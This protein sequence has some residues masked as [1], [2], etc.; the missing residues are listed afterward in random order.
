VKEKNSFMICSQKFQLHLCC[1]QN[2]LIAYSHLLGFYV[3]MSG[4]ATNLSAIFGLLA[5]EKEDSGS[6]GTSVPLHH[7]TQRNIP[8]DL[9][10]H[11]HFCAN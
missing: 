2:L 11:Q 5:P 1:F 8:E 10:L 6:V 7:S 3:S 4:K 9:K